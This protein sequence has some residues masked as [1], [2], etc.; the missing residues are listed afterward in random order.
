MNAVSN[1]L[2]GGG[3]EDCGAGNNYPNCKLKF[4]DIDNIHAVTGC[5]NKLFALS[6]QTPNPKDT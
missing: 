5:Y 1:R 3:Y 6:Y 2:K 4:A